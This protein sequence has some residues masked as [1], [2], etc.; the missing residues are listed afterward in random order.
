MELNELTQKLLSV[1]KSVITE[2]IT[3]NPARMSKAMVLI[4]MYANGVEE[5]LADLERDYEVQSAQLYRKCMLE[6]RLSASAAEKHV[7]IEL[8][9]LKGNLAYFSRV[10]ASAWRQSGVLQSRINHVV[11]F[12]ETTN[13]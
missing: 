5:H 11:K 4:A 6:E 2:N 3:D 12:S 7:K 8:G 10:V 13:L 1:E 9:E